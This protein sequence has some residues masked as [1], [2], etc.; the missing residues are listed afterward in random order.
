[1][2]AGSA[3][4]LVLEKRRTGLRQAREE[5]EAAGSPV[6][7]G[8]AEEMRLAVSDLPE[9]ERS[10]S[11]RGPFRLPRRRDHSSPHRAL[12]DRAHRLGRGNGHGL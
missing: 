9:P 6:Y 4:R 12:P 3:A 5:E 8:R 7:E 10:H 1:M 11:F 2:L